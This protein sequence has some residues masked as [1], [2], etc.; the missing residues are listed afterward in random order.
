MVRKAFVLSVIRGLEAEYVRRHNPIWAELA[1]ALKAHG[2]V[3]YSIFLHPATCQLFAYVEVVDES[4]WDDIATTPV[5][6]RWWRYM[7]DLMPC[8]EDDSPQ[9]VNL[10]EVF[11][12]NSQNV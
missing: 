12:F 11:H 5:C 4:R 7:A 9:S 6:R 3:S 1:Q 2:V 10:R 8:H